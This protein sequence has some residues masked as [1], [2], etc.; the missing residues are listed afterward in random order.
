MTGISSSNPKPDRF[1]TTQWSV[2]IQAGKSTSQDS[3]EALASLCNLYWL[4]L[5]AFAKR[6][7]HSTHEAQDLTQ[8]FFAELLE[9]NYVAAADKSRGRF[10]SFLLTAFKNF[11]SKQWEKANA[12]KRGGGAQQVS[13]DFQK[14][15]STISFADSDGLT[16]EQIYDKQWAL[17][18]LER[19]LHRLEQE[20]A[21]KGEQATFDILKGHVIGD[22][23]GVTYQDSAKRLDKTEAATKK[24]A[25]R[26]R[27]K[28]RQFLREEIA[29]TVETESEVDDEISKL[30]AILSK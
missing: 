8:A 29:Q 7:T 30:F 9:K 11:S 6:K 28:Y 21:Q 18:L 4:P 22:H 12:K 13:L 25:S 24:M 17:T 10:R 5:Y 2:V 23:S 26:M 20:Y 3:R 15:D 19:I 14:A 1:A 27:H 16:A